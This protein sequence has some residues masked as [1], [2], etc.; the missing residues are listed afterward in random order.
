[1]AKRRARYVPKGKRSVGRQSASPRGR[2]VGAGLAQPT[3][4]VLIKLPGVVVML[5]CL[6]VLYSLLTHPRFM[7]RHVRIDGLHLLDEG[8]VR[9]AM[10][11]GAQSV[12]RVRT[13]HLERELIETFGCIEQAAVTCRLPNQVQ[14]A[15]RE[16]QAV[17]VWE[18]GGNRWWLDAQS[19][20]LGAASDPGALITIHDVQATNGDP[21][22]FVVGPSPIFARDLADA[23]PGVRDVDYTREHGLVVYAPE[24]GW[25]VFLGQDGDARLKVAILAGIVS[26]YGERGDRVE[27]VDLRNEATPQTKFISTN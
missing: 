7:V 25:P 6:W 12:F 23:L 20:V 21:A 9:S 17:A 3:S 11:L 22:G 10:A 5:V 1:M 26:E 18:S 4:M 24:R 27:Y 15:V 16:Y 8:R 14:V 2:A 13:R 19:R